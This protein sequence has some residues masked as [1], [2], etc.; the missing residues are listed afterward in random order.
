MEGT[1]VENRLQPKYFNVEFFSP[2]CLKMPM[3]IV[4]DVIGVNS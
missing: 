1:L 4:T 3:T 2:L